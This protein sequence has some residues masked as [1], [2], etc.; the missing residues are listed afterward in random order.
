MVNVIKN[1][2]IKLFPTLLYLLYE[3]K[4]TSKH[5]VHKKIFYD[6]L[7]NS[8]TNETYIYILLKENILNL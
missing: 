3:F 8:F 1:I 7:Q 2:Y 6:W 5:K 4:C